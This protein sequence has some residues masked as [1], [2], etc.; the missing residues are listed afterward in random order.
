MIKIMLS[1]SMVKLGPHQN[2]QTLVNWEDPQL[3]TT[4]NE[5][6]SHVSALH[7]LA[8][9]RSGKV[10]PK[11]LLSDPCEFHLGQMFTIYN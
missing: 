2:G 6:L 1:L 11:A 8:L 5:K 10:N 3:P 7:H 4:Q 9:G